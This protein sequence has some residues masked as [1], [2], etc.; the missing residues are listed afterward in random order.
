MKYLWILVALISVNV[1]AVDVYI[2]AGL[3][4]KAD[5]GDKKVYSVSFVSESWSYTVAHF[6]EYKRSPWSNRKYVTSRLTVQ[7]HNVFSVEYRVFE[8][9][10]LWVCLS[11]YFG[12]GLAYVDR[13][14]H[15]N[16]SHVLF[17]ES[18]GVQCGDIWRFYVRHT[19]NAG[20]VPPNMGDDAWQFDYNFYTF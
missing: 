12:M 5:Q 19:S 13:L 2:G 8:S 14:S 18:L 6:E 16:S 10:S 17:K 15:V 4:F 20:L 11:V 1:F 3:A 9:E 7:T